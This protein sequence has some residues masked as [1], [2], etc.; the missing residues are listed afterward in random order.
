MAKFTS[1]SV[2]MSNHGFLTCCNILLLIVILFVILYILGYTNVRI[3]HKEGM[4]SGKKTG[5]EIGMFLAAIAVG[6]VLLPFFGMAIS[7]M[8]AIFDNS[9]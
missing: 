5:I 4:S 2:K 9:K 8:F 7:K 3:S 6:L 1:S